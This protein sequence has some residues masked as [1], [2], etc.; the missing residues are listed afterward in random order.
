MSNSLFSTS[1]FNLFNS[2]PKD[3]DNKTNK[4][5][6]NSPLECDV[7]YP[8]IKS[9]NVE[10]CNSAGSAEL[11]ITPKYSVL[12]NVRTI[13]HWMEVLAPSA[14]IEGSNPIQRV[15]IEGRKYFDSPSYSRRG[16]VS[17]RTGT[18]KNIGMAFGFVI[19]SE[20]HKDG[21]SAHVGVYSNLRFPLA[22]KPTI[23]LA[24]SWNS[25]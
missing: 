21:L 2:T 22:I 25:Y 17:I 1:L 18:S 24:F 6:I 10:P 16:F 7:L 13:R 9:I 23:G 5:F 8:N 20:N 19:K 14:P 3:S 11:A 15:S 4:S 12:F